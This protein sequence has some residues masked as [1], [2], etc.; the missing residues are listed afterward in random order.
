M[1]DGPAS[2]GSLLRAAPPD[3]L[4]EVTAEHLRARYAADRVEVLLADLSLNALV[5]VLDPEGPVGGPVEQRCFG[6][7]LP[8]N[9]P[10]PDGPARLLLPLTVWGDRLG[11]LSLETEQPATR[12]LT[13]DLAALAGEL[14]MALRT[15]DRD[16]DRYHKVRRRQRL[17]MAAELQWDLLPGRSLNGERFRLAGALE[18]AYAVYGDH[19]DWSITG[20]RLT[21][22]VLNGH[23]DGIEASLLTTV[24]VNAMRN[25][26]RSGAGIVEQGE[27]ASDAVYSRH[28]GNA[29]VA[30]L[31][32]E[33]GLT[34]GAVEAVDAGSPKAMVAHD[35]D[36][37]PITLDQQLPLGMFGD[38]RYETQKFQLEPGDRL[39]VAS[40]GVHAAA[41]GGRPAYGTSSLLTALR[42][43]RLQPPSEAVG[44]V[45]R[46][47]REYHDGLDAEDDA[48]IV[49][50]DWLR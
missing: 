12:E 39:L 33:V 30:T 27:L 36:I 32:L 43:T 50:L 2:V 40:D 47:L 17:T 10:R 41:P 8:I 48:V 13:A 1:F 26:R 37:R 45:I 15:A 19:Y 23:G 42:R 22:T 20:D 44:T 31:L 29:Y 5:P 38:N 7:Q 24:A 14:A 9:D 28:G 21:I 49:C 16:T 35:G 46:S 11:V 34:D 4:P 6:S 18:P 25:A 3:R